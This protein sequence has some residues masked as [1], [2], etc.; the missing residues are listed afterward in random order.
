[1]IK[2]MIIRIKNRVIKYIFVILIALL[3]GVMFH[4]ERYE[5]MDFS[6]FQDIMDTIRYSNMN[7]QEFLADDTNLLKWSNR[8]FPYMY[9][10]DLLFF[11]IS[12]CFENNYVIV[13]V[14]IIIDY[15]IVAYI[16]Y[17]WRRDSRYSNKEV[18]LSILACF[19]LLPMVH[20]CS[21][22]RTAT[23]AC[24][25]SLAIYKFLYQNKNWLIFAFY[26]A[27]AVTFHPVTLF[28]VPIAVAIKVSPRKFVFF[29]VLLGCLFISRIAVFLSNSGNTFLQGLGIKYA[30]YTAENQFRSYRFSM[31]G[32][33]VFAILIV[34]YYF[35][36]Y[37]N[38]LKGDVN[39]NETLA[40]DYDEYKKTKKLFLFYVCYLAFLVGNANSYEIVCRGAYLIGASAPVIIGM[41][42]DNPGSTQNRSVAQIIKLMLAVLLTYMCFC[43][44]R[45]NAKFFI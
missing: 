4:V 30:T 28:A 34:G 6:R 18:F 5:N 42:F 43:W 35:L 8:T 11:L 23:S 13:W 40:I 37:S 7:F 33:I 29:I 38:K 17:D 22:L 10:F 14:S 26:C 41:L 45:Y 31:Y 3:I 19:A 24:F 25:M 15:T 27:I 21:G 16:A 12:K 39:Q 36:I 2:L 44:I 9:S 1:M 32:V 20:A